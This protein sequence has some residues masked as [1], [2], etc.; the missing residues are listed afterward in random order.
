MPNSIQRILEKS[1]TGMILLE[2]C[3]QANQD[4]CYK[5][6]HIQEDLC[7]E[8]FSMGCEYVLGQTLQAL[9]PQNSALI[10]MFNDSIL[11]N[12]NVESFYFD[13]KNRWYLIKRVPMDNQY[14]AIIWSDITKLKLNDQQTQ[15]IIDLQGSTM[16]EL[17]DNFV[18]T[19]M[20]PAPNAP[21]RHTAK[22]YIGTSP[23]DKI[24]PLARD[25][26]LAA[27]QRAKDTEQIQEIFYN[28]LEGDFRDVIR[29]K[30]IYRNLDVLGGRYYI[31]IEDYSQVSRR[32]QEIEQL[33]HFE[34]IIFE[35]SSRIFKSN[36]NTIDEVFEFVLARIGEYSRIDRSYIFLY[37][38]DTQTVSNTHEWCAE[39]ISQEIMNLQLIP[40][41]VI[42]KSMNLFLA[43][44]ALNVPNTLEMDESWKAEQ[45]ILLQQNIKSVLC[46]PILD[47]DQ[48]LGFIGFDSV[49]SFKKWDKNTKNLL[50]V[51]A[52][53][54]AN[55]LRKKGQKDLLRLKSEEAQRHALEADRANQSKSEFL[56]NMSHEIR[57]P[58]NGVIG[59]VDLLSETSLDHIQI[60]YV[61]NIH[62]AANSLRDLI[63]QILDFSKIEAGRMELHYEETNLELLVENA[64]TLT[65][66]L[67]GS[68]GL[69]FQ[70]KID[71]SLPEWVLTD[72]IRLRQVLVN[73]LSN[74]MKFTEKG[75]VKLSV[76]YK[77]RSKNGNNVIEF[78]VEDSGIGISLEQQKFLFHAFVQ[79]D[80]STTKKYGGTGLGLVIS[81]NLLKMMG[82]QLKLTSEID[83]GT[84]F[85][86]ELELQDVEMEA[87]KPMELP[88]N[89]VFVLSCN[90][91][92]NQSV[93]R[94]LNNNDIDAHVFE[95]YQEMVNYCKNYG[96][97]DLLIGLEGICGD[98][99]NTLKE[100]RSMERADICHIPILMYY[101]KENGELYKSLK[102]IENLELMMLPV[103]GSELL[104]V[105]SSFFVSHVDWSKQLELQENAVK[106][107]TNYNILIVE[108]NQVNMLLTK[109]LVHQF[110]P[111]SLLF[112]AGNGE[113]CIEMMLNEHMDIIL[114]D[115][116]M[117]VMDGYQAMQLI[118][119][120]L[121]VNV[122]IIALTANAIKGEREHCM[123][124]GANDYVTKPIERSVLEKAMLKLLQPELATD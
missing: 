20:F 103:L 2:N 65:R 76:L 96:A 59:F 63:N 64:C 35:C 79:A 40:A 25:L 69:D 112:E 19:E 85:R 107:N 75:M 41:E 23:M 88:Y 24:S 95:G 86:F 106:K 100:L 118:R 47:E 33:R 71:H 82:S 53:N 101:S 4:P 16:V 60:Q 44:Q 58:L 22:D 13:F 123:E 32:E 124:M 105:S 72:T 21:L 122:P 104:D 46:I 108:D 11:G 29:A 119:H 117:P 73:L 114:M 30:M 17:N 1:A 31:M 113:E 98:C 6:N 111:D 83:K 89:K 102:D 54:L 97:P 3:S 26:Y 39:G 28:G 115:I 42:H 116:Q 87:K 38:K 110:F 34:E 7:L 70:L 15:S 14:I 77:G 51:I 10:A 84:I 5:I 50:N 48:F 66:H 94:I 99:V 121:K 49:K 36:E 78:D 61:R 52:D 81:N 62:D 57:T 12:N 43:G 93:V 92:F 55:V 80:T 109:V 56:A 27:L 67:A 37:D 74:A 120:S 68:K 45:E 90:E 9:E 91:Q 8:L 18:I